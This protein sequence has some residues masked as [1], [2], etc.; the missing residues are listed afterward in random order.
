MWSRSSQTMSSATRRVHKCHNHEIAM[1]CIIHASRMQLREIEGHERERQIFHIK[2]EISTVF[3]TSINSNVKGLR[4][5]SA[6][7]TCIDKWRVTTWLADGD[8]SRRILGNHL[9]NN[10][11]K[12][13]NE[14]CPTYEW[15]MSHIW[16]SHVPHMNE[17]SF[18][19]D[20]W[21]RCMRMVNICISN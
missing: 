9:P 8:R 1:L 3:A 19:W 20:R 4:H 5:M 2:R 18:V 7:N 13:M 14:S 12:D 16:M 10:L 17:L 21:Q 11:L 6:R 15:V